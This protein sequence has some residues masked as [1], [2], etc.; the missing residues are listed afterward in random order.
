[1][2]TK[3]RLPPYLIKQREKIFFKVWQEKKAELAMT[4]LAAILNLPL[5]RLYKILKKQAKN[6]KT[7]I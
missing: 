7:K 6:E 1:M 2:K 5:D 4:E 3:K